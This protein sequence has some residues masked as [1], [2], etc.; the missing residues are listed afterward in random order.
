MTKVKVLL[1][2]DVE[3]YITPQSRESFLAVLR[4]LNE[5]G[6]KGIFKIVGEKARVLLEHGRTDIAEA[7]APHEIG[8]HTNLHSQ[9]PVMSEYLEPVGFAEGAALFDAKE[10]VGLDDVARFTGKASMTFGQPGYSWAP[11]AYPVLRRWGVPVYVDDHDHLSL[12]GKPFWYGGLLSFTDLK[13]TMRMDLKPDGLERAK[14][15]FDRL[16]AD[17]AGEP[18]AFVSIYYHPC[19]FACT[20][21]WDKHNFGRGKSTPR[22]QWQPSPLRPE[23]EMELY[24]E[25]LGQFIDYTLAAGDVAYITSKEALGLESSA[26]GAIAAANVRGLAAAVGSELG[27]VRLADR[28]LSASEQFSLFRQYMLGRE[29]TAETVYGPERDFVSEGD[30][31]L[32][33]AGIKR[34]IAEEGPSVCGY[35]Q[36]PDAYV[37]DGRRINPVDLTCTMAAAIA[38][39]AGDGDAVPLVR[40]RLTAADYAGD[41]DLW[42]PRWSI[43]PLDF[44]APNLVRLS[45]LQ[46]WTLKPAMFTEGEAD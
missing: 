41:N 43:F 19:E 46:A 10:R 44:R 30:G 21:F 5:R 22:E 34:A 20:S 29:L 1:W 28:A 8:Y 18:I 14:A 7:L 15:D 27:F 35:P 36:L 37:V 32:T 17:F 39:G 4:M 6:V 26:S 11:H 12:E 9:H 24:V 23:G 40:G 13:G 25:R 3:D 33:V 2:F 42:G 45:K 31:P 16:L 38:Q